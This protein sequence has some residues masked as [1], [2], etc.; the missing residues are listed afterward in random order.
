M[1]GVGGRRLATE[2]RALRQGIRVLYV[3]GHAA[4][5]IE[6]GAFE[7]GTVA[8]EATWLQ[9]PFTPEHLARSVRELLDR[10]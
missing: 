5:S 1:P 4:D 6:D 10:D 8:A 9:K 2:L 3:S 7:D